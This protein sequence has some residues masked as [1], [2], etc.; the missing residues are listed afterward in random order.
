M[1]EIRPSGLAGGEAGI[2]RPSLP[3]SWSGDAGSRSGRLRLHIRR[4]RPYRVG[5]WAAAAVKRMGLAWTI[6]DRGRPA[7]LKAA[8][9]VKA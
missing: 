5:Q 9:A 6:R 2:N 4:E 3:R 8:G 1:R 7:K